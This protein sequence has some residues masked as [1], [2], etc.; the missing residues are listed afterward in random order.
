MPDSMRDNA[1]SW[2]ALQADRM[3]IQGTLKRLAARPPSPWSVLSVYVN[4][5]PV[6]A[7][8]TTYRPFLK[9]RMAEELKALKA[10]SSCSWT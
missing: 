5:R 3:R 7:Q 4:T 8:M 2:H 9:R 10:R 6:G 1:S